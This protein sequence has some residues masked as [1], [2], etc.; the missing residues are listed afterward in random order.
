MIADS[1]KLKAQSNNQKISGIEEEDKSSSSCP[2]SVGG[3]KKRFGEE[4]TA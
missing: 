3:K 2:A 1:S 4:S